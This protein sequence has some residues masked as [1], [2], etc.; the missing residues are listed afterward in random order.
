MSHWCGER[1]NIYNRI[2]S[3]SRQKFWHSYFD[4]DGHLWQLVKKNLSQKDVHAIPLGQR[5]LS[6]HSCIVVAAG[7][8][9]PGL[10]REFFN[11]QL[12]LRFGARCLRFNWLALGE[13]NSN[14]LYLPGEVPHGG[15]TVHGV[16]KKAQTLNPSIFCL[17]DNFRDGLHNNANAI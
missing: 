8:W 10:G 1:I 3:T 16:T 13:G 6:S 17:Q 12:L 9:L 15:A 5:F 2:L 11:G 14:T 7:W 4:I